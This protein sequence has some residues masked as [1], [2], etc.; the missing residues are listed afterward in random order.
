M[1]ALRDSW[2]ASSVYKKAPVETLKPARRLRLV[3]TAFEDPDLLSKRLISDLIQK[4]KSLQ[5]DTVDVLLV[6][7]D[8]NDAGSLQKM[9]SA[10]GVATCNSVARLKVSQSERCAVTHLIVNA[11]AFEDVNDL[12]KTLAS[13]RKR[14]G[15][16]AVMLT[17]SKLVSNDL[18]AER[19]AICDVSLRFPLSH[20]RL[21]NGILAATANNRERR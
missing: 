15:E 4:E 21:V 18:G 8:A 14:N 13:F 11:D 16:H 1:V 9:L 19:R 12:V 5:L 2:R 17:S 6:G 7:F 20:N 10:A 3:N